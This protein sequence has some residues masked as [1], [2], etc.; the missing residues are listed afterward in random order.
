MA[1]TKHDK[2]T[3]E[4]T[5]DRFLAALRGARIAGPK[6]KIATPKRKKAQGKKKK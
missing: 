5:H 1:K 4:E 3:S 6:H 2:F